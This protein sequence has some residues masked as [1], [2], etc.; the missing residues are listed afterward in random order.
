MPKKKP[1]RV[2]RGVTIEGADDEPAQFKAGVAA[3]PLNIDPEAIADQMGLWWVN[4]D[5]DK[6]IIGGDEE[7]WSCWNEGK[8]F[9]QMRLQFGMYISP[10]TKDDERI[11]QFDQILLHVMKKR[12]VEKMLPAIGG[13]PQGMHRDHQ[14]RRFIVAQ[15]PRVIEPKAGEWPLIREIIETRMDLSRDGADGVD[16]TKYF[17]SWLKYADESRMAGPGNFT[18]GHCLIMAGQRGCGKGFIQEFIITPLMGG[19]E[20]DPKQFLI[21]RKADDFNA[22]LVEAEH[23]KQEEVPLENQHMSTRVMLSERIKDA[24]TKRQIRMRLMRTEPLMVYPFNRLSISLNDDPDKMRNLPLMTG[25]FVDKILLLK[26][27]HGKMPMVTDTIT[28]KREF[29]EAVAAELPAFLQW[30]RHEYVIPDELLVYPEAHPVSPGGAAT[31]FGFM[32]FQHPDLVSDLFDDTPAAELM[33][34]IDTAVFTMGNGVLE[35]RIWEVPSAGQLKTDKLWH[36]SAL[37]LETLLRGDH[38]DYRCSVAKAAQ[39]L[40]AHNKC[41]RMLSR[42]EEDQKDGPYPRIAARRFTGGR[43]GWAIVAPRG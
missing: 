21:A 3:G 14:G 41:D 24:V 38:A 28:Q 13:Y 7:G 2:R 17:Y 11:S 32:E 20:A 33:T 35:H 36:D 31:R 15:G 18:S 16:Q 39:K 30:L 23:W 26:L 10:K 34:L 27:A 37:T 8:V 9:R 22:E 6:Y 19:R 12:R 25:D 4:G 5:G 1:A 42:L 40:F 43:R 29:R